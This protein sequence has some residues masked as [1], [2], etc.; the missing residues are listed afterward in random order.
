MATGDHAHHAHHGHHHHH[1]HRAPAE[2]LRAVLAFGIALNLAFVV[3]EAISGVLGHSIA[4]LADAGHNLGDVLSLAA[5]WAAIWLTARRPSGRYTYG[6]RSSSILV[7]LF[8]AIVLLIAVGAITVEAVQRLA[9]P[10]PVAGLLVIVVALVGVAVNGLTALMLL[11]GS[12]GDLNIRAAVVHMAAD[13]LVSVGVAASGAIILLTGWLWLD[14]AVS[15]I[16]AIVI[17]A[18]TWR[19]LRQ[20]LDMALHAV[21]PGIDAQ[22]V[23]DYLARVAGVAA[24]H[25]LHIW[26]MSTTETALTAHLVMPQ[27]HP[28]DH[29]L[30]RLAGELQSRFAIGHVTIQVETDPEHACALAPDHVV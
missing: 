19:L 14:P 9:S 17:V 29:A 8:N 6:L 27:G 18:A 11:R 23:K 12:Q 4:L 7:A 2:G 13:A 21:P 22:A 28:G 15:I 25:D 16:V 20:A 24:I 5:S 1:E 10:Q 26:P 30:G 3:I